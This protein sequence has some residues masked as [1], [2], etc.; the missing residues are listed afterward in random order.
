MGERP[1]ALTELPLGTVHVLSSFEVRRE[2][3]GVVRFALDRGVVL[4]LRL[5]FEADPEPV[6]FQDRGEGCQQSGLGTAGIRSS[7]GGGGEPRGVLVVRG[8]R[9]SGGVV[10]IIVVVIFFGVGLRENDVHHRCPPKRVLLWPPQAAHV[11]VDVVMDGD[12]A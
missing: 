4:T 6:G 8:C 11:M 1:A 7:S 10:V 12:R 9:R 3:C 5:G 2:R